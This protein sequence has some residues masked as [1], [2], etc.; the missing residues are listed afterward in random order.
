VQQQFYR[1]SKTTTVF[2]RMKHSD[3]TFTTWSGLAACP[4]VV[5]AANYSIVRHYIRSSV[6][7]HDRS[8]RVSYGFS[9]E[10]LTI[11]CTELQSLRM[12]VRVLG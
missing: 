9:G 5:Q 2:N 1:E 6:M 8:L 12:D 10:F 3:Q 4:A 11:K 7:R